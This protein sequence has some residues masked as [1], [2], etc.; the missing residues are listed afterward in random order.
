MGPEPRMKAGKLNVITKADQSVT[1][2]SKLMFGYVNIRSVCNKASMVHDHITEHNLDIM[3]LNE[4]W[5][6]KT[7][8]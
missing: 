4:T 5:M 2:R 7:T 8:R 6:N 1:L 3:I